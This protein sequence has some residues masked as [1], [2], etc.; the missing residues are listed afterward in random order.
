MKISRMFLGPLQIAVAALLVVL[1]AAQVSPI[2]E[3]QAQAKPLKKVK[4][5]LGTTVINVGY[6]WLTLPL[7]L[8]YWKAEGYDV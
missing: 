7:A 5:A 6:P 8:D 2:G 4:I 3:A 1:A